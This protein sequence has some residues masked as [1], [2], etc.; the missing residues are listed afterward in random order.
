MKS[1]CLA[2]PSSSSCRC[3]PSARQATPGR[4]AGAV[5]FSLSLPPRVGTLRSYSP[6]LSSAW[7]CLLIHWLQLLV[8]SLAAGAA[9]VCSSMLLYCCLGAPV[10]VHPFIQKQ[11]ADGCQVGR[12]SRGICQLVT[13]PSLPGY[14]HFLGSCGKLSW[15][16][17][18]LW[19]ATCWDWRNLPLLST[20]GQE[21]QERTGR[22]ELRNHYQQQLF[23][24]PVNPCR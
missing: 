6:L 3:C 24:S 12:A 22:S 18:A 4:W 23:C 11:H 1:I 7:L 19:E 13:A 5:L 14:N 10:S 20:R 9:S 8:W 2:T 16:S 21:E 15:S 17:R